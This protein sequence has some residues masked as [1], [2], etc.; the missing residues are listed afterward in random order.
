[1]QCRFYNFYI[2]LHDVPTH[3]ENYFV[4]FEQKKSQNRKP[5]IAHGINK[6]WTLNKQMSFT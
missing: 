5:T 1:M 3:S 4:I 2:I 6:A